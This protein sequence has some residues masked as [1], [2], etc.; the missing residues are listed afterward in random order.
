MKHDHQNLSFQIFTCSSS[1]S[2][3]LFCYLYISLKQNF[4]CNVCEGA[5]FC[6]LVL[7]IVNSKNI[8][9]GV[10]ELLP[11]AMEGGIEK[12]GIVAPQPVS[13][14]ASVSRALHLTLI[15]GLLIAGQEVQDPQAHAVTSQWWASGE[16]PT[17]PRADTWDGT[18]VA[19]PCL[20]V[21]SYT[22]GIRSA[23]PSHSCF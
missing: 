1:L 18:W 10:N 12:F 2:S 19:F 8:F 13:K 22:L 17:G 5:K 23:A 14:F 6:G 3:L 21:V 20:P 7:S 11:G 15:H 9:F 16:H 4:G